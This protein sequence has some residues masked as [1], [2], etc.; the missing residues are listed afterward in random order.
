M[1]L[2]HK[3]L[4]LITIPVVFQVTTVV[5]FFNSVYQVEEAARKEQRAKE[6]IALAQEMH[7]LVGRSALQVFA[8]TFR[9]T[10][11][12]SVEELVATM[13]TDMKR[14]HELVGDNPQAKDVLNR[15]DNEVFRFVHN[16][17]AL[18]E[19]FSHQ[20]ESLVF[21][22][23]F[24]KDEFMDSL[25]L[26]YRQL[27]D[28]SQLLVKMYKPMTAELSPEGVKARANSRNA[29][30]ALAAATIV[31]VFSLGLAVNRQ[32]LGRLQL[33]MT[34]I[35]L[36]AKGQKSLAPISGDDELAELD[37]AFRQMS[38]QKFL[39]DEIQKSL[40]AMVSHDLRSPLSSIGLSLD[41]ILEQRAD[42]L[43]EKTLTILRRISSEVQRLSRLAR[44]L[45]DIEKLESGHIKADTAEVQSSVI[46]KSS[47]NAV[48]ALAERRGITIADESAADPLLVCDEDRTIQC[49]V[50]L[51][52]NAIKFAP[53]D[54]V[55][56]VRVKP[57]EDNFA[58]FEVLDK[59]SG[60]A[61]SQVPSLFNK[62][63]QLDQ[64]ESIKS[65]GSGL[66]LY[67][68]RL[69]VEAQGGKIG[70]SP[71]AEIGSCFWLE[72]PI[73]DQG[74]HLNQAELPAATS[75]VD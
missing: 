4:L 74:S 69:L 13:K 54:S 64:P 66:G 39:L 59:G 73:K 22:Q 6:A 67:I 53:R 55:V 50:N 34:N 62:F 45:L 9:Q 12:D 19:S 40:R 57:S 3:I 60:I 25:N 35:H 15:L 61:A 1:K 32:V 8:H 11:G 20:S 51:V 75:G 56:T 10:R 2:R 72:L 68:C 14:L 23:F 33:L 58:R 46:V 29:M 48:C 42:S 44:T 71:A 30:T 41:V 26:N 31:L 24:Y 36:F 49:I 21:A 70:Y 63:V 18:S 16:S 17:I 52:S 37:Q 38:A 5:V 28:D 47:I 43:D 7:A 65:G 27:C